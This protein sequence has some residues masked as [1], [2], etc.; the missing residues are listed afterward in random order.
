LGTQKNRF[1]ELALTNNITKNE[2]KDKIEKRKAFFIEK[3]NV[4]KCTFGR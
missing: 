1:R 3:I 2:K 4:K